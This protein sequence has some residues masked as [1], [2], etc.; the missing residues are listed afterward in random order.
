MANEQG[1]LADPPSQ[2]QVTVTVI[3]DARPHPLREARARL[4]GPPQ[5]L[6]VAVAVVAVA[7]AALAVVAPRSGWIGGR[8]TSVR[9]GQGAQT[10]AIAAA[11]GY[12]H[13]CLGIT[14]SAAD[15]NYANAHVDSRGGCAN[16]HGY[17]NATF[18]ERTASGGWCSTKAS[19][20]CPTAGSHPAAPAGPVVAPGR[21]TDIRSGP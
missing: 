10:T 21:R 7:L 17:V 8:K 12:P 20:S 13:Q 5:A 3:P 9:P 6:A 1:P 4:N 15:P 2:V 16:Y 18:H 14:F 11:F 19:C